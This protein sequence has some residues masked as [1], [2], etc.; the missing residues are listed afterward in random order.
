MNHWCPVILF[1]LN[2]FLRL[3]RWLLILFLKPQPDRV[4]YPKRDDPNPPFIYFL[5]PPV[6]DLILNPEAVLLEN[7]ASGIRPGYSFI[8]WLTPSSQLQAPSYNESLE[9]TSPSLKPFLFLHLPKVVLFPEAGEAVEL[10][11]A[12][13][14]SDRSSQDY[15]I[16]M[17]NFLR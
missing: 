6:G 13:V 3:E 11:L 8:P 12:F 4:S 2:L 5:F 16:K 17:N 9:T 7:S 10:R 1:I 14:G 15:F